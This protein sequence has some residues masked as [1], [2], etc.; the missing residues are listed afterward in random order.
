[1]NTVMTYQELPGDPDGD[2]P[3]LLRTYLSTSYLTSAALLAKKAYA[4]E[5]D[6]AVQDRGFGIVER[7]EHLACASAAI[8]M[9]ALGVEAFVNELFADCEA[10]GGRNLFG[11]SASRADKLAG[12]WRQRPPKRE[13]GRR[14]RHQA[15]DFQS[16]PSLDK[17]ARVLRELRLPR[18]D[19]KTEPVKAMQTLIML[20]NAL[21]HYKLAIRTVGG[22]GEQRAWTDLEQRVRAV[23]PDHDPMSGLDNSYIPDRIIGHAVAEWSVRTAVAFLEHF[24]QLLSVTPQPGHRWP[25]QVMLMTR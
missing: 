19:F 22:Q 11:L 20:R 4:I 17:Y 15:D 9:S 7:D 21:A 6:P 1:M 2:W 13:R 10:T 23:F 5:I 14:R 25:T 24:R 18:F 3:L 8:I 12:V 16:Q